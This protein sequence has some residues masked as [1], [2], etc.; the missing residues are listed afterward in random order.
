[1]T[2]NENKVVFSSASVELAEFKTYIELTSRLCWYGYPNANGALLPVEG[3]EEKAQ[4]LVHQPVVAFYK[5]DALGRD[6]LGGHQMSVDA[7]GNVHHGT[8]SV[9]VNTS[10]EVKEDTVEI[11]GE[12]V[13]T[14]CLFATRRIW[15]RHKN[16][17]DAIKR[18]HKANK[19]TS[20]W[21]ILV[22]SYHFDNG[23]K[24]LEDYAFDA[25]ALLGSQVTPAF[26]CAT[27]LSVAE[28]HE[29][30]D[31]ML[32]AEALATDINDNKEENRMAENMENQV[33]QENEA[34]TASLTEWDLRKRISA[35][36]ALKCGKYCWL[37]FH[38]PADKIVWVEYDGRE[39]E[40]DYYAFTY[41]VVEDE[42][43]VSEPTAVKLAVVPTQVNEAL[44]SKDGE[45]AQRDGVIAEKDKLI[46]D[47]D[48][49]ISQKNETLIKANERIQS[50]ESEISTLTPY[51]EAH[52]EAERQRIEAENAEKRKALA[53][54]LSKS[55]LFT[56]EELE[57][58]EI[59]SLVEN[60][61][62]ASIKTQ[63]ADRFMASL[64]KP[65]ET[66]EDPVTE[67][68]ETHDKLNLNNDPEKPEP[69]S[70]SKMLSYKF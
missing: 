11:N 37:A 36:C 15:T 54:K 65:A 16:Y 2:N 44:A 12:E 20:S 70:I 55:G 22:S 67:S 66:K 1:M 35:A 45:I 59:K 43:S 42:V 18:L 68:A 50:L 64:E 31:T 32:L 8:Y 38:F 29:D 58:E 7:D 17:V 23:I 57:S 9:G 33:P 34:E 69:F 5:K 47:K 19:L 26:S 62:E 48:E 52:E 14:P 53:E 25:D 27:T 30:P 46:A 3:A 61:D 21:E 6:D 40:L 10:V 56:V 60:M 51:K 24:I 13:T 49:E 63:I 41:E 4:T 28:E 39:T